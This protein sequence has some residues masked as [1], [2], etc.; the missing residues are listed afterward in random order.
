MAISG[1]KLRLTYQGRTVDAVVVFGSDNRNSLMVAFDALLDGC[2]G[3]M[4]IA[5]EDDG[6]TRNL[7]TWHVVEVEWPG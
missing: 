4:A 2:A 1:Q 5:T 7:M 6:T 3:M